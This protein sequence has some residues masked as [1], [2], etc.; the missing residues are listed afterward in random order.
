MAAL[1]LL[2]AF[3]LGGIML[4]YGVKEMIAYFH[5]RNLP[6]Y[7]D[8]GYLGIGSVSYATGHLNS[9]TIDSDGKVYTHI[10]GGEEVHWPTGYIVHFYPGET[11]YNFMKSPLELY[12]RPGESSILKI[13]FG[14]GRVTYSEDKNGKKYFV[15]MVPMNKPNESIKNNA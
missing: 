5:V 1:T 9:D 11:N 7:S 6:I 2:G 12:S 10:G 4:V 3:F 14:Y 15:D 8:V 13:P